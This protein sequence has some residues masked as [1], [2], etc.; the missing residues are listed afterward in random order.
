M[1]TESFKAKIIEAVN[2]LRSDFV[3]NPEYR[4]LDLD[5]VSVIEMTIG[6]DRKAA[7]KINC[8]ASK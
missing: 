8:L 5:F 3:S 2:E 7:E 6:I 4:G 1:K